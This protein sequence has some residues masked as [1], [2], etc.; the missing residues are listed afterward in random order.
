MYDEYF[1]IKTFN[2]LVW[3]R[4]LHVEW[5][6][7]MWL[8]IIYFLYFF[9]SIKLYKY[10]TGVH[11]Y[12]CMYTVTC[13][14]VYYYDL[15]VG[16]VLKVVTLNQGLGLSRVTFVMAGRTRLRLQRN[17][18]LTRGFFYRQDMVSNRSLFFQGTLLL[19]VK[20]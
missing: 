1:A 19:P 3:P 11:N 16:W 12:L 8:I 13:T 4:L 18:R 10:D 6:A 14:C 9:F 2:V 7:R 17:L 15:H 20:K 5:T